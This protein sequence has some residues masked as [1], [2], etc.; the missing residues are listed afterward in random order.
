VL[1]T[2]API[3]FYLRHHPPSQSFT[4][5][6]GYAIE[7]GFLVPLETSTGDQDIPVFVINGEV[8]IA[9]E[10]STWGTVKRLFN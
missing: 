9:N 6:P 1:D 8:P 3:R 7:P 5:T 10:S 2:S 4:E